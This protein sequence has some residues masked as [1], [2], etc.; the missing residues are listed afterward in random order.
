[1]DDAA[2]VTSCVEHALRIIGEQG[3]AVASEHDGGFFA[4]LLGR[5]GR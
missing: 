3:R 4:R 2:V 1:M 5:P